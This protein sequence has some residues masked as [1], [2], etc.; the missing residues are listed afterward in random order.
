MPLTILTVAYP[1]APVSAD[2]AGGA[3]QIVAALDSGIV[4]AG[5]RSIVIAQAGSKTTGTLI[6]TASASGPITG[7][8]RAWVT[9]SHQ[10]NIDRAFA[11]FP[12]D[13]VH[14][15]GLDFHAYR[16][17]SDTPALATLHLPPSWYP[18]GIWKDSRVQLQCVSESQ[19]RACPPMDQPLLPVI[20]NGVPSPPFRRRRPRGFALALG[21]ILSGKKFPYSARCWHAG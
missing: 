8:V 12:I 14:F 13:L 21:R 20:C 19:R 9:A 17:P 2:T 1:F 10:H 6:A 5:H 15:H 7:E 4:H 11:A 16:I 18:A 3:E